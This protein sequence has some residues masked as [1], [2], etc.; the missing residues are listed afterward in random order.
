MQ[1]RARREAASRRQERARQEAATRRQALPDPEQPDSSTAASIPSTFLSQEALADP[2]PSERLQTSD[3]P[4]PHARDVIRSAAPRGA[5]KRRMEESGDTSDIWIALLTLG[6]VTVVV[7]VIG[8]VVFGL[9]TE[10]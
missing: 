6:I 9:L 5:A 8:K 3:Q 7:W 10:D 1:A 2:E 4:T